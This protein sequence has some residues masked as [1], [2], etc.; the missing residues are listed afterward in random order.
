MFDHPAHVHA[1]HRIGG[2]QALE[3][4]H[5]RVQFDVLA[6]GLDPLTVACQPSLQGFL[7]NRQPTAMTTNVSREANLGHSQNLTA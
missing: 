4:R 7:A 5:G 6:L 2:D 1:D 3:I